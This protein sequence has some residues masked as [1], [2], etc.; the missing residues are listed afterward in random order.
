MVELYPAQ[1]IVIRLIQPTMKNTLLLLTFLCTCVLAQM[2]A[3]PV[4]VFENP[5]GGFNSPVDL[6]GAGDGS[7]RLFIVEQA[8]R[9]KIYDQTTNQTLASNFLD[10]TAR[11][12]SGGERGLL[13]VAF[14]P[15]FATNG[16][17]YVNY[18]TL[19][20]NGLVDG[21]TVI[22]R[23]TV[24]PGGNDAD[25]DSEQVLLT[26]NQ[27]YSNHNAGDLA[28]GPDGYLYI[29]VGDGG[30]GGDPDDFSQNNRSLLGKMLRIDVDN[31]SGGNNYGIPADNPFLTPGDTI[32]DEIYATGLR[33]PWR[34]SFDRLTGDLWIGDVGQNAREEVNF[35]E[36]G[37]PGGQ[38]YGWDCREGTIAFVNSSVRCDD[39]LTLT[40]PVFDYEHDFSTGGFSL[41]GGFVYRGSAP[42]LRGYYVCIDFSSRRLFLYNRA[43][44]SLIRQSDG[45]SSVSTF[46]EDDNGELYIVSLGGTFYRL[47][48]QQSLPVELTDWTASPQ[49]KTVNLNWTTTT[50][51]GA[52]TFEI[53][54]SADGQNF[55]LLTSLPATGAPNA[56]TNYQ[57]TDSEPLTGRSYYRLVQRDVDGR[58]TIYEVRSVLMS[59][60][61]N[62]VPIVSPNPATSEFFVEVPELMSDGMIT[63]RMF[64]TDGRLVLTSKQPAVAGSARLS[65]QLPDLPGGVYQLLISYDGENHSV[66]LQVN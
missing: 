45:I 9:I 44:N 39:P 24:T 5:V 14:H 57:H 55:F 29:P 12:R 40:E 47:T 6:T 58:S 52:A 18:T 4:I 43:T 17:F 10:I 1:P 38:N 61:G 63:L 23:Y 15:D 34:I 31:P 64:S 36:A 22:A 2:Q 21:T 33:N 20:R 41:T 13:G 59:G 42:D 50:E 11:V 35:Q 56:E 54:R 62:T 51:T 32:P 49:A 60:S 25:E 30:S 37:T 65:Y 7:N 8:G 48:T 26:V 3:Q 28:F 19:T 46:G 53:E 66:A 27:P 16:F